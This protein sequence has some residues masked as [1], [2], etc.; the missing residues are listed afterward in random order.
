M[1]LQRTVEWS[2]LAPSTR[3]AEQAVLS[4][5]AELFK[6]PMGEGP[7]GSAPVPGSDVQQL[8]LP[9]RHGG[10]GLRATSRL[11]ADAAFV[12]GAATA[13]LVMAE[14]PRR[15]RPFDNVGVASLRGKW[16]RV[17]DELAV[18]CQ[19][20]H[21]SRGMPVAT[22]EDV[23]PT[24]T[25]PAVSQTALRRR[26]C[27]PSTLRRRPA[28]KRLRASAAL[29][30]PLPVLGSPRHLVLPPAWVIP[31]TSSVAGTG[32]G[33]D[34]PRQSPFAHALVARATLPLRTMPWFTRAWQR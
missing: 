11:S 25:Q 22:I 26:C 7:G 23:L 19:W 4:A 14:A 32:L 5:V 13:Q 9:I 15:F 20:P 21:G 6:L 31:P 27:R 18:G 12:S 28:R 24:A 16:Q 2:H 30:V 3:R 29:P 34:C 8:L 33:W 1:H 10:F 17:H